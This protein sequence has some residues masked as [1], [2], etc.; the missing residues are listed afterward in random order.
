[1]TA[2][3]TAREYRPAA[4]EPRHGVRRT[5]I[6]WALAWAIALALLAWWHSVATGAG[7][8]GALYGWGG[9]VHC[10][11]TPMADGAYSAG[12]CASEPM[13]IDGQ[14]PAFNLDPT[15]DL[16]HLAAAADP[17]VFTRTPIAGEGVD[18]RNTR[19]D[20][21]GSI[22]AVWYAEGQGSDGGMVN[23]VPAGPG[24]YPVLILCHEHGRRIIPGDSGT[25]VTAK[26]GA[27]VGIVTRASLGAGTD[28]LGPCGGA[29]WIVAVMVP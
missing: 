23:D 29:Q 18:W 5:L 24:W 10:H 25:G 22:R 4:W 1:M 13:T 7:A 3:R 15:R 16:L 8:S 6:C 27:L 2:P 28:P 9:R 19:G 12:H 14:R 11:Y 21:G 26:D 17:S 20:G